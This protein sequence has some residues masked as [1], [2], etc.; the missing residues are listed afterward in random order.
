MLTDA[1]QNAVF[2]FG[3]VRLDVFGE[4]LRGHGLGLRKKRE[5]GNQN[6]QRHIDEYRIA[7]CPQP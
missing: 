6:Y 3:V 5:T 2:K 1:N 4:S 7:R